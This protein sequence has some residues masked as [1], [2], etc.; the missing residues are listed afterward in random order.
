MADLKAEKP[1]ADKAR[2]LPEIVLLGRLNSFEA[3]TLSPKSQSFPRITARAENHLRELEWRI[4]HLGALVGAGHADHSLVAQRLV[5]AIELARLGGAASEPKGDLQN[6]SSMPEAEAAGVTEEEI[7]RA[8]ATHESEQSPNL[9]ARCPE[10]PVESRHQRYYRENR[11]K[12]REAQRLY[13]HANREARRER[14]RTYYAQ[15]TEREQKRLQRF[16]FAHRVRILEQKRAAYAARTAAK[17]E[18]C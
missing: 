15:N 18:R 1:A 17:A 7:E 5:V 8:A 10:V 3:T 14:A 13:Y 12:I 9:G 6:C 2:G 16:Y 11:E 4:G